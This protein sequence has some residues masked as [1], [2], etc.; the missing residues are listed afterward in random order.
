MFIWVLVSTFGQVSI[1]ISHS[2]QIWPEGLLYLKD[3]L[4]FRVQG[5]LNTADNECT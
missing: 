3:G 4:Q 2:I 1:I 5:D